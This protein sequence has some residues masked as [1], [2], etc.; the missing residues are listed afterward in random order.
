MCRQEN[1]IK[2]IQPNVF[3]CIT[4]TAEENIQKNGIHMNSLNKVGIVIIHKKIWVMKSKG[5]QHLESDF[6]FVK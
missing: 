6:F 4:V 2:K 3:V 1:N 5:D